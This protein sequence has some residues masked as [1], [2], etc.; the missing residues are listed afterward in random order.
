M[1]NFLIL[2]FVLLVLAYFVDY[3][4]INSFLGSRYR[5]FVAPGVIVHESSHALACLITG[6]KIVKISFFSKDGG[7]VKHHKPIVPIVGPILISI[8]PLIVSIVLFYFLARFLQLES[9]LNLN[10]SFT[11]LKSLFKTI[12]FTSWLN[13]LIIYVI[14]S[15]AVT[16]TPSKQDLVNMLVPL[17]LV[18]VVIFLLIRFSSWNLTYFNSGF[19]EL[20]PILNLTIFVLLVCLIISLVFYTLTK[21]LFKE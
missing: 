9:S 20:T 1:I 19:V 13:L 3:F 5:L 8:A 10:S 6:A 11:N 21:V 16:M 12:D 17:A 7:F 2:F 4:L 15:I 14:L 18:A